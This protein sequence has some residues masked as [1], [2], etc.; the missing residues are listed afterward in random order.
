MA[1]IKSAL[2]RIRSSE[3]RRIQN[4]MIRTRTRTAVK[5]ARLAIAQD[6][7]APATEEA[8]RRAMSELDRAVIKGILHR[9]NAA[10][11]KSRLARQ[12]QQMRAGQA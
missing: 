3:K 4:R 10:R 11:R 5:K 9:N 1:N 8:I 7:A 2:K 6:A 12:L